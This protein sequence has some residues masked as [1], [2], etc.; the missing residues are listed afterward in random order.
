[1]RS[2]ES[3]LKPRRRDI[4]KNCPG[5][6]GPVPCFGVNVPPQHV[7]LMAP[8]PTKIERKLLQ[9]GKPSGKIAREKGHHCRDPLD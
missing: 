6:P 3:S 8:C 4:L 7:R 9:G 5:I 1:M 2:A